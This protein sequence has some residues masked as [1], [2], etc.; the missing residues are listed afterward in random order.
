MPKL[1][2]VFRDAE[3]EAE[4]PEAFLIDRADAWLQA[5]RGEQP[6]RVEQPIAI[7]IHPPAIEKAIAEVL[8]GPPALVETTGP[9]T[10]TAVPPAPSRITRA[11]RGAPALDTWHERVREALADGPLGTKALAE[12]LGVNQ[13]TLYDRLYQLRSRGLVERGGTSRRDSMWQLPRQAPK[14]RH[15]E[16][17][18]LPPAVIPAPSPART[19]VV[20]GQEFDVVFSGRDSLTPGAPGLGSTLRG[21]A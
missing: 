21:N 2:M 19:R 1:R 10:P 7:Q 11:N 20:D 17:H 16:Q 6:E 8:A 4:G 3:F 5:M 9:Q 15:W 12:R 18:E 13:Y 14:P